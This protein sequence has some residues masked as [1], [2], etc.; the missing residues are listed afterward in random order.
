MGKRGRVATIISTI[1]LNLQRFASEKSVPSLTLGRT[2]VY[3]ASGRRGGLKGKARFPDPSAGQARD[4]ASVNL[5]RTL[6]PCV[7]LFASVVVVEHRPDVLSGPSGATAVVRLL[8]VELS[9]DGLRAT[10]LLTQ[11]QH[12]AQELLLPGIHSQRIIP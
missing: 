10:T 3:P 7:D 6:L 9:S 8:G 1:R 2:R 5:L 4:S 12:V 11:G